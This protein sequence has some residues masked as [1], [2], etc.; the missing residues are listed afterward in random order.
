VKCN[1]GGLPHVSA[2]LAMP[3]RGEIVYS[4]SVL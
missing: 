4:T 3:W 1:R 2:E